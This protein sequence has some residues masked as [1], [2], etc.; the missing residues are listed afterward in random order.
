MND[1]LIDIITCI[2]TS[3]TSL[4]TIFLTIRNINKNQEKTTEMQNKHFY[5]SL[6]EQ[7]IIFELNRREDNLRNAIAIMPYFKMLDDV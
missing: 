5:Q 4:I 3:V 6:K 7:Q 1:N 2:I